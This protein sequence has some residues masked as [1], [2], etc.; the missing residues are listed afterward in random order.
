MQNFRYLT[1]LTIEEAIAIMSESGRDLA[2]L[3]GGTNLILNL[4][5]GKTNPAVVMNIKKIPELHGIEI[6]QDR[7]LRIGALTTLNELYYS[8]HLAQTYPCLH[9][10][11]ARMGSEQIRNLATVGGNLCNASPASDLA[12][13]LIAL[14]TTARIIGPKGKREIPLEKFFKGPRINDL[15]HEELLQEIRIPFAS[16]KALYR[17]HSFGETKDIAV[18]SVAAR[19]LSDGNQCEDARIILGAVAPTPLRVRTAEKVLIGKVLSEAT[20]AEAATAAVEACAP[21]DDLR[22]SAWYRRQMVQVLTR[23]ILLTLVEEADKANA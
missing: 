17:K 8:D 4:R 12:P 18:V 1:P 21:I 6:I 23:R 2:I 16:G 22:S 3:A 10:T 7:G 19:I 9:H 5:A 14:D 15:A 11:V 13:P 20:I